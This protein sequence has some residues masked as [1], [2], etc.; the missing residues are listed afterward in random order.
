MLTDFF[1]MCPVS[2]YKQK[3]CDGHKQLA[4]FSCHHIENWIDM[5]NAR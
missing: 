5:H 3:V 1:P 4:F 2:R